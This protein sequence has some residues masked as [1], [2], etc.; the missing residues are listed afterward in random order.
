MIDIARATLPGG[1]VG[2]YQVGS[3]MSKLVLTG[4]GT[5]V[6]AFLDIVREAASDDD[7]AQQLWPRA[8]TAPKE[9]SVRL[10]RLTVADVPA[11]LRVKF[12]Q[13][14]G[15]ALP[16]ERL[17]VDVIDADDAGAFAHGEI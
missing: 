7:V 13:L 11:E 8:R 3:G 12:Q 14:Y 15:A 10:R 6:P 1:R 9:L 4:F 2:E 5:S 17:L 16:A